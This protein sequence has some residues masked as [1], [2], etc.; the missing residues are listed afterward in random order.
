MQHVWAPDGRHD[1]VMQDEASHHI[2]LFVFSLNVRGSPLR[3]VWLTSNAVS[4]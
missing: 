3:V 1:S 2:Q 4:E